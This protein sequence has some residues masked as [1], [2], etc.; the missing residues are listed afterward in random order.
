MSTYAYTGTNATQAQVGMRRRSP[1]VTNKPRRANAD[2]SYP[3]H[4]DRSICDMLAGNVFGVTFYASFFTAITLPDKLPV[5]YCPFCV[6]PWKDRD[7]NQKGRK[8]R[9]EGGRGEMKKEEER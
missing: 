6:P 4:H 1:S 2:P 7:E 8:R 5:S 9:E 3:R